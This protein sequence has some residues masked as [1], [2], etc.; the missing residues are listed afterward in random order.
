MSTKEQMRG[1]SA[2][3]QLE[4]T[5]KYADEN[6]LELQDSYDDIGVSAFRSQNAV[7]GKLGIFLGLVSKGKIEKGSYL[8]IE[9]LDRLSRDEIP[10]A[11][12]RLNDIILAGIIVVTLVDG[13]V[14]SREN[15]TNNNLSLMVALLIMMRAH[16]ESRIKSHRLSAAWSQK[17][18]SIQS[19]KVTNQRIPAWLEYANGHNKIVVI[20]DRAKLVTKMF[21]MARD[22]S[23]AFSICRHLNVTTQPTWGNS[24][25][26]QESYIKKILSVPRQ[27]SIDRL[28]A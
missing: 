20:K 26:W 7:S 12:N 23:G 25:V 16:E 21:E 1:D 19:G 3:R 17:R 9:S 11:F 10:T 27:H 2:R 4:M 14:F 13:Q 28:A 18:K 24:T 5:R 6:G 15:A 22:G 8:I